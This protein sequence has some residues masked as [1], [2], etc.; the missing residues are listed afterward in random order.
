ML[1]IRTIIDA[2]QP[3][4]IPKRQFKFQILDSLSEHFG[5]AFGFETCFVGLSRLDSSRLRLIISSTNGTFIPS[6]PDRGFSAWA[7]IV[8]EAR[9]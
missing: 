7:A 2:A 6:K 5:A 1:T 4:R 3:L 8:E 9:N